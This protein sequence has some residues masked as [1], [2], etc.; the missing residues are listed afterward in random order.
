MLMNS[1]VLIPQYGSGQFQRSSLWASSAASITL[2]SSQ[3][4]NTDQVNS[5][6]IEQAPN[7]PNTL[8]LNPSIRIRSIPTRFRHEW[9]VNFYVES[10]SLNTDQVNSHSLVTSYRRETDRRERM[11][12]IPQ[13]G[14]GQF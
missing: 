8:S 13:Y 3:S 7:N 6:L 1:A 12:S 5:N 9:R 14:S 11:V 2:R 10:Q 4:L